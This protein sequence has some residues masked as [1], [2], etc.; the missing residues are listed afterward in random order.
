[1]DKAVT[2]FPE[3]DSPT[4]PRVYSGWHE[5]THR[6]TDDPEKIEFDKMQQI[7]RLVY[8]LIMEFGNRDEPPCP[9]EVMKK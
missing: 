4:I 6:P 9:G 1:M 8:H 7:S 5:D 3:P 2:V